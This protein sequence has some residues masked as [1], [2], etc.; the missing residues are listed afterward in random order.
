VVK[1]P[2]ILNNWLAL[3]IFLFIITGVSTLLGWAGLALTVLIM[4]CITFLIGLYAAWFTTHGVKR[5]E[6][7][8]P[9]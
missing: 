3:G 7:G 9:S 4:G 1:H 8:K 6:K 2:K 5:L